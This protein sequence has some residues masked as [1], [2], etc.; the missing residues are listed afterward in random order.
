MSRATRKVADVRK[1]DLRTRMAPEGVRL[2]RLGGI[3][4][5][6]HANTYIPALLAPA[7]RKNTQ[8]EHTCRR[9]K[10]IRQN[11]SSASTKHNYPRDDVQAVAR[12]GVPLR[13]VPCS[14][15]DKAIEPMAG[16]NRPHTS[17]YT[18]LRVRRS[19]FR[20][21]ATLRVARGT[22]AAPVGLVPCP[23]VHGIWE[24]RSNTRGRTRR[25]YSTTICALPSC[26]TH[27]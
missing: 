24:Q 4:V 19:I 27:M 5:S 20:T 3:C 26:V 23:G 6:S 16:P 17:L 21:S 8:R 7:G 18:D 25:A 15:Q 22:S 1:I 14:Y 13:R 2:G 11:Q 9:H 12:N 10:R